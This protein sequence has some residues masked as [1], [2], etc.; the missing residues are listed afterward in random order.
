MILV[1]DFI[2]QEKQVI[3]P[4][5]FN[6]KL[7]LANL[8][9]PICNAG[10]PVSDKVGICLRTTLSDGLLDTIKTFAF[11]LANNHLMDFR[12][13]GLC[14][15]KR[16]LSKY[17]IPFAGAGMCMEEARKPMILV[18]EGKRIA[19]F[20]CSERQFGMATG[21]SSG[22]AERGVWL[23]SAIKDIKET[24]GAD[25]VIVSCHSASEY[26]PWV[27]PD[28]RY[29]YHSLID[30]GADCIH[31]HHA[32]VPQGY[33]EYKGR[34]IFYGLGNFVMNPVMWVCWH[35]PTP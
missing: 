35:G 33:E 12:E 24:G 30:A 23:Y 28:L 14:Q 21:N 7:I 19:V 5:E 9:G 13:E 16:T 27:A 11:S 8:E 6:G 34:P 2:P 18:E 17:G 25:F 1:G 15:T 22:C 32:H 20:S 31:G 10:L 26:S 3:L 4:A 29:F